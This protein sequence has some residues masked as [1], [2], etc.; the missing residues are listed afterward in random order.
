MR[1]HPGELRFKIIGVVAPARP[2][3]GCDAAIY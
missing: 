3:A 1:R 2:S